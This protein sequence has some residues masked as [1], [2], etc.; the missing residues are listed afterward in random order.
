MTT[1]FV[2][3]IGPSM[4]LR[5]VAYDTTDIG[6][7]PVGNGLTYGRARL[8]VDS[9]GN[10]DISFAGVNA[11]SE[12]RMYLADGT[13]QAGIENCSED[14]LLVCPAYAVGS[15]NNT[16]RV[17]IVHPLYKIKEFTYM[18]SVG[19]QTLPVQQEPDKWYSNPA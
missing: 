15:A 10:A 8:P 7:W 11:D 2:A 4:A 13:E 14:H 19:A 9:I 18:V 17:V 16:V 5:V 12:I 6:Q 3:R 1:Q